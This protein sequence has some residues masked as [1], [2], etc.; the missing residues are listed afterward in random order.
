[1]K[2]GW[3]AL[4]CAVVSLGCQVRALA[5]DPVAMAWRLAALYVPGSALPE[6]MEEGPEGMTFTFLDQRK[7]HRYEVMISPDGKAFRQL[8]LDA[9]EKQGAPQQLLSA[10]SLRTS[11]LQ[12]N[13]GL[14]IEG[15]F[16]SRLNGANTL[17]AVYTDPLRGYF[18]RDVCNA[19]DGETIHRVMKPLYDTMEGILPYEQVREAVLAYLPGGVMLDISLEKLGAGMLYLLKVFSNGEE[20][21]LIM[22]AAGGQLISSNAQLSDL[23]ELGDTPEAIAGSTPAARPA[24]TDASAANTSAPPPSTPAA[25]PPATQTPAPAATPTPTP[26]D[27]DDDDDYDDDNDDNDWVDWDDWDNWDDWDD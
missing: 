27:D 20:H 4:L 26:D 1:M 12:M 7:A 25:A 10:A 22:D 6:D 23:S 18:Y 13:S 19:A 9:Y 3:L 11:L 14:M 24:A 15:I 16:A 21:Y 8:T 5:T 17:T 2:R